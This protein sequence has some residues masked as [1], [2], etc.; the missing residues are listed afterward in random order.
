MYVSCGYDRIY[1]DDVGTQDADVSLASLRLVDE[2]AFGIEHLATVYPRDRYEWALSPRTFANP[3]GFAV[4]MAAFYDTI[5]A[6]ACPASILVSIADA[7]V[8]GSIV[9][10]AGEGRAAVL[11]ETH[12]PPDRG[13]TTVLANEAERHDEPGVD[14]FLLGSAGSFNYG[15]WLVD[16]LPR[17]KGA[18]DLLSR[19]G[20]RRVKVMMPGYGADIDRVRHEGVVAISSG[21]LS[22]AFYDPKRVQSYSRLHYASPVSLH[23]IRKSP[24]AMRWAAARCIEASVRR[25]R[26]CGPAKRTRIFVSRSAGHGRAISNL[27]LISGMLADHGFHW[28]D[29][30]QSSFRAQV[31]MFEAAEIVIGPMGAAMTNALFCRADTVVVHLAPEG[32][33]EPFYL[34]LATASAQ[35][36]RVLYGPVERRDVLPHMSAFRVPPDLLS[37]LLQAL[38]TSRP[39]RPLSVRLLQALRPKGYSS[40]RNC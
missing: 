20:G 35:D 29:P 33:I 7:R 16:D 30:G 38:P 11:Y 9:Y 13:A 14:H 1:W 25:A 18:L 3:A 8:C 26:W 17:L 22:T 36:Y 23:P 32:W 31:A 39:M 6:H 15:H 21:A 37:A 5:R 24:S 28:V 2:R 10:C 27:P 19:N 4:E 40:N 34:D 12:L